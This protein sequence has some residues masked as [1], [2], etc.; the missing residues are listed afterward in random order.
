[1][2][3]YPLS[4]TAYDEEESGAKNSINNVVCVV[5][6]VTLTTSVLCG[7]ITAKQSFLSFAME[8]K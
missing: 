2:Y 3:L 8:I 1:M 7:E 5:E 4:N 6:L